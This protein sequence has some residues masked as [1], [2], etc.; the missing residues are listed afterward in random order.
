MVLK[1]KESGL[2]QNNLSRGDPIII[3]RIEN[4]ISE[5][6]FSNLSIFQ[7]FI[8]IFVNRSVNKFDLTLFLISALFPVSFT[9]ICLNPIF[10]NTLKNFNNRIFFQ[11]IVYFFIFMEKNEKIFLSIFFFIQTCRMNFKFYCMN[12]ALS[13]LASN[14]KILSS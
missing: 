8:S 12:K 1:K 3:N 9:Q 13:K 14:L 4:S 11:E 5:V 6:V 7:K 2:D 10:D